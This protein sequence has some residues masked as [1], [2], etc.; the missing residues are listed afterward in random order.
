MKR[1]AG[2]SRRDPT[3]Q[4]YDDGGIQRRHVPER[5]E[6]IL[7]YLQDGFPLSR[8]DRKKLVN[9]NEVPSLRM[10]GWLPTSIVV[11]ILTP[12][13]RMGSKKGTVDNADLVKINKKSGNEVQIEIPDNCFKKDWKPKA[14]PPI[15]VIDGQHRLWAF[16]ETQV[17]LL[18]NELQ[19]KN[20]EVLRCLW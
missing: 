16:E 12:E 5:S 11:N 14:Y 8:I 9:Q 20:M 15:E 13:C 19:E 6:E 3:K 18:E 1:L 17:N 4:P 2:I 7:R 10:P